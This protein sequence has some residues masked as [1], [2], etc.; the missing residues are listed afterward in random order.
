MLP[1]PRENCV[2]V[3]FLLMFLF[4]CMLGF[5]VCRGKICDVIAINIIKFLLFSIYFI[6]TFCWIIC[7]LLL[8]LYDSLNAVNMWTFTITK[9]SAILLTAICHMFEDCRDF[10]CI[11]CHLVMWFFLNYHEKLYNRPTNTLGTFSSYIC[12]SIL[13]QFHQFKRRTIT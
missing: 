12:Y 13:W 2:C 9:N 3:S 4:V 5:G 7:I 1:F 6:Y 11:L 10:A 8:R